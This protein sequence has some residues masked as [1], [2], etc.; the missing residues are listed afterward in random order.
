MRTRYILLGSALSAMLPASAQQHS[1]TTLSRLHKALSQEK[2]NDS[3]TRAGLAEIGHWH[4]EASRSRRFPKSSDSVYYYAQKIGRLSPDNSTGQAYV[5]LLKGEMAKQQRDYKKAQDDANNAF[6]LFQKAKNPTGMA[7]SLLLS[8]TSYDEKADESRLAMAEK[9]L[10]IYKNADDK[11]GQGKALRALGTMHL[12]RTE[13]KESLVCHQKSLEALKGIRG[14]D[15]ELAQSFV[16]ASGASYFMGSIPESFDYG[17]QAL[18]LAEKAD[19]DSYTS[20]NA[21]NNLGRL[22]HTTGEYHKALAHYQR[23]VAILEG[24]IPDDLGTSAISNAAQVLVDM[25]RREEALL[26][27][28]KLQKR[29]FIGPVSRSSAIFRSIKIYCDLKDYSSAVAYVRQAVGII[30]AAPLASTTSN[31]YAPV[32]RYYFSTGQYGKAREY[33]E[34][35]KEVAKK[36]K[37]KITYLQI[38]KQLYQIDSAQSAFLPAMQNLKL[39]YIYRDSMFGEKNR[40]Q[41]ADLQVKYDVLRKDRDLLLKEKKNRE[42]LYQASVQDTRLSQSNTTRNMSIA[43][44]VILALTTGLFYSRYRN[45]QKINTIL[46]HQKEVITTSNDTLTRLVAEKEWLLK[47]IHHRVKNNLHIVMSLLNGQSY[48]L[49]DKAALDAIQNSQHRI[50]SMSLIHQKL[51]MSDNL[52]AIRMPEYVNELVDYLQESFALPRSVRFSISVENVAMDVSQ[53]VP[54]GLILNEAITNCFKYAF[55]DQ[56]GTITITLKHTEEDTFLLVIADN[57]CGMPEGFSAQNAQSLG[58]KL[59]KGLADDLGGTLEVTTGA[60]TQVRV[61]F[62]YKQLIFTPNKQ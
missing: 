33:L 32:A 52:T 36:N 17:L 34:Q 7:E 28:E 25:N 40:Q 55:P 47:E 37:S 19:P 62:Q 29:T 3:L 8:A 41:I 60:G 4:V 11:L 15:Q 46:E 14:H 21:L 10:A 22:Y 59:I 35:Y 57:G 9:A 42:L 2:G 13:Y 51:Y 26:Y 23:A 12:S 53:A 50:Q 1:V 27:L 5:F 18:R 48:F 56:K 58:M 61:A 49:K 39:A 45:K 16:E 6:A 54:V 44:A 24:Y 20:G 43:G 30:D 38:Y 31:L